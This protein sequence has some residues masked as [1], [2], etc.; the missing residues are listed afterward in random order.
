MPLSRRSATIGSLGLLASAA[1][2]APTRAQHGEFFG[3]AEGLEDFWLATDAYIY[4]YPLVTMEMTRRV[5]SNVA[6]A[7]GTR[8]P[9]GQFVKMRSYPDATFRDVTAPNADTLYTSA[10]IDVGDEPW[11]LDMP[12]MKDSYFRVPM[13]DGSTDVFQVPGKR[14]IGT[15]AQTSAMTGPG[16]KGSL[17]ADVKE[18]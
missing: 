3:I 6:S 12:D 4:G 15:K 14:A 2:T 17:R 9:M 1:W 16:W 11:V 5:L 13:R 18:Y 7:E 10:W 8:A